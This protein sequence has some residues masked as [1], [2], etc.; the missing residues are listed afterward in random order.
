MIMIKVALDSN[1]LVYM[2]ESDERDKQAVA[3]RLVL[4]GGTISTQVVSEYINVLRR[5]LDKP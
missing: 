3:K 1:V 2:H 4:A 5:K